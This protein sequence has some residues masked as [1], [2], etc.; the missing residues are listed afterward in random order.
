[1]NI[2][3]KIV[4]RAYQKVFKIASH[5]LPFR[6][7]ELIEGIDA[8][9]IAIKSHG[10][11]RLL[12]VTDSVINSLGL[13]NP[14]YK[15]LEDRNIKY[16]VYDKVIP[17][18]TI[19]NVEEALALYKE[20]DCIGIVAFGG[21][22]VIDC[23]KVVGARVVR[24]NKTVNKMKGLFKI[25]KALPN[26]YAIPTTSGTGSEATIAAVITDSNTHFKYPINDL[27]LIPKYA[28]LDPEIT[29]KLPPKIT[30]TTGMDAL[31]HAVEAY[32]GNSN[33]KE[34][35]I[36]AREAVK[37][38]FENIQTAYDTGSDLNARKKMQLASYYAGIAFTRAYVGYVH[39]VAHSLGG[40]YGTPHGLA[41]AVI[42]PH[43]LIEYGHYAHKS[44]SELADLVGI[45]NIGDTT[46][47]KA[48]K[49][50]KAVQELNRYMNIPE[51][52]DFIKKEDIPL[53]A[54]RAAAEGNPLYPVP[55]LM[56]RRELEK[57][58]YKISE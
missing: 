39:A 37:L 36:M 23:A 11:D 32:I 18:P 46:M 5:L 26:L 12:I 53:M 45:T 34:T 40:C 58:Y 30:S 27:S 24:P 50:I 29:V 3:A 25:L 19:D 42:L 16:V 55:K 33:T 15:G 6:K 41:N 1:M 35:T 51:R 22:S 10:V 9:P 14:L 2:A 54:K 56:D 7:P 21:G 13:I 8:L 43:F 47:E 52:F 17:N 49:F 28:V 20:H 38:I 31:T 44:L 48:D 4:C 57:M